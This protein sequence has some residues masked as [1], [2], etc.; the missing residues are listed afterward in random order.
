MALNYRRDL[1]AERA[2]IRAA[3][4]VICNSR[5]TRDDVVDR[6]G[7]DPSQARVIYYGGDPVRFSPVDAAG[8]EAA[9][10]ALSQPAAGRLSAS[11]ARSG[12]D[13]RRSTR[14]SAPGA[15]YAAAGTGTPT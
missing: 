2:A 9:K 1:A 11:S 5:R 4:V 10:A 7:I 3:R 8:R 14:C 13:G 12:I 6:L 15:G